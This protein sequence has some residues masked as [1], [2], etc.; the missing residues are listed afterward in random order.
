MP[1][2]SSLD[3]GKLVET[4]SIT[5]VEHKRRL[6]L[7]R[8]QFVTMLNSVGIEFPTHQN[9]SSRNKAKIKLKTGSISETE[10]TD[11][12][13]LIIEWTDVEEHC[14]NMLNNED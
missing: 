7:T 11:V 4:K 14:C 9:Y 13:F 5:T 12:D 2:G 8:E 6:V 3:M 1:D 10:F